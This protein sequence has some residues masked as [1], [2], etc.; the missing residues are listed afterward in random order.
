M[1]RPKTEE[2]N[3]RKEERLKTLR[4]K[5]SQK[6]KERGERQSAEIDFRIK[7][8][9]SNGRPKTY[10]QLLQAVACSSR[11]LRIHLKSL[12]EKEE[13][14]KTIVGDGKRPKYVSTKILP[15]EP[16][17]FLGISFLHQSLNKD[18]INMFNQ[19]LGSFIT[20]TL[21]HFEPS[22]AMRIISTVL[23]QIEQYI[24]LPK[25]NFLGT[26]LA[27]PNVESKEWTLWDDLN[28][29]N[30]VTTLSKPVQE[31]SKDFG[32][33]KTEGINYGK[34]EKQWLNS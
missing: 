8:E 32:L 2:K 28:S 31:H 10:T 27:Q 12:Q 6:A 1:P 20:Y 11:T 5:Q 34:F 13:I 30:Y 14:S 15:Y 21:K 29:R 19:H 26:P 3:R 16:L 24:N 23:S 17:K 18:S 9:L 7:Q 4:E 33:V 22:Q 25:A